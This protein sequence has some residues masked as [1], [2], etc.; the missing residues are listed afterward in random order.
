LLAS[1]ALAVAVALPRSAAQQTEA[2]APKL[3]VDYEPTPQPVVDA[4]LRIANVKASDFLIDLGSG[5]GRIPITAAKTFGASGFGVDLDP[6]RIKEARA[7][8]EKAKVA[9]KV[10]FVEGDL[11][12]TSLEKA[13]V[14]TLF[15]YPDLNL[16]LRPR[17]LDL[18]PGTRIVSH[19]HDMGDW[20]PDEKR[21]L[22]GSA[23]YLWIVPAK[24]A[25]L[26]K[27]EAAGQSASLQI[28]QSFQSLG[29][30]AQ[31]GG[32]RQPI[33]NGRINGARVSF[34]IAIGAKSRRFEGQVGPDGVMVGA[35][36]QAKPEK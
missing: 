25:G 4:M 2:P 14:I 20:R 19:A 6:R 35:D 23:I 30:T 32:R 15:L 21:V 24:V 22:L 31:T 11:F 36:W 7:N 1:L 8:A 10:T 12:K 9:D 16:S 26:W 29:G 5:D 3:D 34:E 33:R 28:K 17:L 27:L 13:S 18:A